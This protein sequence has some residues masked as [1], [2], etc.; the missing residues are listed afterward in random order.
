[1]ATEP[2]RSV[3]KDVGWSGLLVGLLGVAACA[4]GGP[5]LTGAGEARQ[6]TNGTPTLRV[7]GAGHAIFDARVE[8]QDEALLSDEDGLVPWDPESPARV[9]ASGWARAFVEA[10]VDEVELVRPATLGGHVVDTSGVPVECDIQAWIIGENGDI[11]DEVGHETRT[12]TSGGFSLSDV[13]PGTVRVVARAPG[14]A[15]ESVV[16]DVG[17]GN[18][19]LVLTPSGTLAGVVR[20]AEGQ[21]ARGA[22]VILA[23]SGVWPPREY[24]CDDDG[25]YRIDDIAPGVYELWAR[26]THERSPP[27]SGITLEAGDA[28]FIPLQ[29]VPGDHV[30]GIVIDSEGAPIAGAEVLVVDGGLALAPIRTMSGADGR[31]HIEPLLPVAYERSYLAQASGY[32]PGRASAA[33]SD[34]ELRIVLEAGSTLRGR[35]VDERGRPVAGALVQWLMN[36]RPSPAAP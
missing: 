15:T 13:A 22:T 33:G 24:E 32:L 16:A 17:R 28:L 10:G 8:W 1:M 20:D 14:F 21:P 19:R 5:R 29:M 3:S 9:S 2:K 36:R 35:V 6:A 18:L 27:R 11:T 31:F 4:L 26:A 30:S 23:G 7:L 12:N 34:E 25:R